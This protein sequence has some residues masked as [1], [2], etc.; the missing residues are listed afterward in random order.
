MKTITK[1]IAHNKKV[2]LRLD[3]D[4]PIDNNGT[5]TDMTRLESA[6]PTLQLLQNTA[7]QIIIIGHLGRPEGKVVSAL[8]LA[9][10]AKELEKI[11]GSTVRF[12]PSL[13]HESY[14]PDSIL[15]LENLRFDPQEEINTLDFAKQLATLAE[16]FVFEAFAVSHR[17]AASTVGIATLLPSYGG[18]RTFQEVEQLSAVLHNPTH[19]FLVILGG[20]KIETK[21]PMIQTMQSLADTIF[22]GG[23]LA[24]EIKQ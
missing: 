6:L 3:L 5:V 16:I 15:M 19:P 10:V 20:A 17:S 4:V 2:L 18:L 7:S 22:V 13:S 8:S 1:E 21:L 9:P 14:P 23:K 24:G 12:I 11:L